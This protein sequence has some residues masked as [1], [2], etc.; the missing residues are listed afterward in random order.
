LEKAHSMEF[1]KHSPHPVIFLMR[2]WFDYKNNTT[3][4]R[5]E[6]SDLGGTMRLGAYPC[7]LEPDSLAMQAYQSAEISERHRHRFEFNNEYRDLL[8]EK[9]MRFTGLSPDRNLVEVIELGEHPWFVGCQFHPE[10]K[11]RPMESHPLF[12]AFVA[13]ALVRARQ[14]QEKTMGIPGSS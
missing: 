4:R 10:F 5:T 13:N 14:R 7:I 2:E 6:T 1:D 12:K 3:V 8:A 11:S 9:G